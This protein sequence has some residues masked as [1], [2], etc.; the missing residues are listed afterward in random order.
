MTKRQ[1][2]IRLGTLTSRSFVDE[3]NIGVKVNNQSQIRNRECVCA[4][5]TH[6]LPILSLKCGKL[7]P[8]QATI[9]SN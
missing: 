4:N 8:G 6:Q 2:H 5:V 1:I 3:R 7:L 9:I